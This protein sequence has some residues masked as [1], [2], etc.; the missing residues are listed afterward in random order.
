MHSSANFTIKHMMIAK[1][2]GGFEKLTGS[3]SLDSSDI[4]RSSIEAVIDASSIN[5][6]EAQR[7]THLKSADFFDV[8]KYPTL[9]FKSTKVE[10]DGDDLKVTGDLTI[11]GI[12]KEVVLAVEGPTAEMK[13]PYGNIKIGISATTKIKRKDF[14]LSWNAALEAGGVLVGDDVSISLDVQFAKQV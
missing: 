2:H 5:T 4:T 7:D 9:N 1:V 12:T 6:R 13:D 3:L 14:G 10:K 8:E 11:H